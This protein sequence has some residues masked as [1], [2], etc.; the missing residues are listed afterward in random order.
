MSILVTRETRV[1]CQGITGQAGAFH[2]A[3]CL[4]Y[5]TKFVGGV[6]P[7]KGGTRSEHG[8]PVFENC[9][10]AI[11]ATGA[12]ATMV[13]V[14]AAFAADAAMEA[15]DAGASLV[16]LITEGIPTLDMVKVRKFL[17]DKGTLLIGPNC[18]GV[19]TPGQCKIGIM[20]G[21]IHKPCDDDGKAVGIISRSGTLTY[22]AVWQCTTRGI[23]QST[24]VG[25]GGDPVKG[26]NFIE[27][28]RMFQDDDDTDAV[29]MIGEIGGTDEE[30]A[31]QFIRDHVSKPVVAF[32]AGLT[33]P[34]GKRMGHAGAII[35]GGEGTADSKIRAL[36]EAGVTV[37]DSPA[38]IGESVA[39]LLA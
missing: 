37:A 15:A 4:T 11:A 8:L 2:T 38:T 17:D 31:A 32:V 34:P 27:L 12:E 19:I 6:T 1:I 16:V 33:A 23:A 18:P 22:E 9:H 14:P 24:C 21:Y 36:R 3:Q 35:S 5:G 20:P 30:H 26:L 13:F 10:D 7:G 29:V 25:I 28:L 39:R